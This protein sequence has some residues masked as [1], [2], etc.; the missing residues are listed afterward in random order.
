M[1]QANN[2]TTVDGRAHFVAYSD[3]KRL[4]KAFAPGSDTKCHGREGAR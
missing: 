3:S 4:E 2:L 1:T